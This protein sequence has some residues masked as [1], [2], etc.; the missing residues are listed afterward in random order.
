[1]EREAARA[2]EDMMDEDDLGPDFLDDQEG[3]VFPDGI[4]LP[5]IHSE[6]ELF[7]L[8]EEE[9]FEDDLPPEGPD[10][11]FIDD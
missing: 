9:Y 1:M 2:G 8:E 11:E 10:G 6:D 5:P 7:G 3:D 4:D